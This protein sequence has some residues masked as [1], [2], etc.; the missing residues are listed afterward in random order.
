MNIR[1]SIIAAFSVFSFATMGVHA[2]ET[3]QQFPSKPIK[4]IFPTRLAAP[5][6]CWR[7]WSANTF[8][9]TGNNR[10]LWKTNPA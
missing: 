2:A 9:I 5:P 1:A 3:A 10:S 8:L 6:I 7:G 4:I